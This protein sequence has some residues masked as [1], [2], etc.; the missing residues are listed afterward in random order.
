MTKQLLI[1]LKIG[2]V[3]SFFTHPFPRDKK[4][5]LNTT[6]NTVRVLTAN[7]RVALKTDDAKGTGWNDRK[8]LVFNV[9]KAQNADIICL[10]EVLEVQNN[11]FKKAFP[12]YTSFGFEGPEMDEFT[13]G[14]YHLIAK[15]PILFNHRKFD[16]VSGGTYWLSETPHLGGSMS[17]GTSRARHVNWVRLKD[18]KTGKVFRVLNAHLDHKSD[19]AKLKQASMILDESDQYRAD[20]CQILAGDFNSDSSQ[21]PIKQLLTRW[22]DSYQDVHKSGDPGFTVH[23]FKGPKA[24]TKK[25]KVDFIFYR[26]PITPIDAHIIKDNENGVYPSDHYFVS[27]TFSFNATD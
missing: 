9:V 14:E 11:D 25:G 21:Q 19:E 8:A 7:I 13:D 5:A 2:L 3:F 18:K 20:F 4:V 17:W 6:P 12:S 1:L 16:F 26:G 23:V 15:N 10:Q 24:T 27:S 22:K